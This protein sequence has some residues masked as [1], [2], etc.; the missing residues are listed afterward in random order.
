MNEIK[1]LTPEQ[2]NLLSEEARLSHM[3]GGPYEAEI[4]P[5]DPTRDCDLI[6]ANHG[7][8]CVY[9][10]WDRAGWEVFTFEPG[11]T[12]ILRAHN[13]HKSAVARSYTPLNVL[14][15]EVKSYRHIFPST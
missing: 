7:E 8:S 6:I 15:I 1:P 2:L 12:S 4:F 3:V 11:K 13:P 9:V 14:A 10:E 5:A